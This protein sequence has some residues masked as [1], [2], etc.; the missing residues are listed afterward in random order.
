MVRR[1]R[2]W[3]P[4]WIRSHVA[5]HSFAR[6]ANGRDSIVLRGGRPGRP[7]SIARRAGLK[8]QRTSLLRVA[9]SRGEPLRDGS[10]PRAQDNLSHMTGAPSREAR[11][12]GAR[13]VDLLRRAYDFIS[14]T[15]IFAYLDTP[16]PIASASAPYTRRRT[17]ASPAPTPHS[18]RRRILKPKKNS[19]ALPISTDRVLRLALDCLSPHPLNANDMAEEVLDKLMRN[20]EA[21]DGR[22][23]PV[24]VRTNPADGGYQ[25][26]D[27]HQRVKALRRLGHEQALC[28]L[29]ECDDA[30]ALRLLATLN[31][32]QGE[33]SPASRAQLLKELTSAIPVEELAMLLPENAQQ[34][35]DMLASFAVDT[36][37][38]L[39]QVS[40]AAEQGDRSAPRLVSFA[41]SPEDETLVEQA[42]A[43]AAAVLDGTNQ[44]GRALGA[45]ARHYLRTCSNV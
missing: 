33:D 7:A 41:L 21:E 9:H 29:W 44:R 11:V 32:L 40:A 31:R 14:T 20:I 22:Y 38:L 16:T 5:E 24:V 13:V 1:I 42:I 8:T 15:S 2:L 35:E 37:E 43:Q 17:K 28:Y 27:G 34:I 39:A 36:N 30:T 12:S 45:I 10:R 4:I 26:L 25:I 6:P 3:Q 23:P 18:D 19:S